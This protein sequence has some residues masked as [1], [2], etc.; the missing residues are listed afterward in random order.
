MNLYLPDAYTVY[1]RNMS[2]DDPILVE[3]GM[4]PE[5]VREIMADKNVTL[6]FVTHSLSTAQEFCQRGLVLEK[7]RKL[8]EGDIDDAI[9]FYDSM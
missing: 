3:R 4:T 6:L 7:G 2:A 9:A 8:Y 5:K 1:T